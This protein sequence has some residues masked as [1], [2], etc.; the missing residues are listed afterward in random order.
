VT[1]SCMRCKLSFL[2][3]THELRLASWYT[4]TNVNHVTGHVDTVVTKSKKQVLLVLYNQLAAPV[5]EPC[6]RPLHSNAYNS[7]R[8]RITPYVLMNAS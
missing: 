8:S 1:P 6:L 5:V 7:Q 4:V 3:C 2:G